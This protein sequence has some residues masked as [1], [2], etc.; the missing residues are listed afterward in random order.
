ML[1]NHD[2][3]MPG[4]GHGSNPLLRGTLWGLLMVAPF[5]CAV[6]LAVVLLVSA[7]R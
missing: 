1:V 6:A 4:P 2:R 5:W 3:L 7:G